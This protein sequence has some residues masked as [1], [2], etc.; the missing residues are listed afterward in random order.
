[1]EQNNKITISIPSNDKWVI[2]N[3]IERFEKSY[4]IKISIDKEEDRG[5]VNFFMISSYQFTPDLIFEIGYYYSGYVR[6]L[7]NEDKI[8]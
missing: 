6:Q 4:K 2:E 7:R 3:L 1:M 8:E 5:G